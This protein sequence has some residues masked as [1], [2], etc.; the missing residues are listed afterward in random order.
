MS[1]KSNLMQ[2]YLNFWSKTAY[3]IDKYIFSLDEIEHGMLRCKFL[4]IYFLFD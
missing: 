2:T 1:E 4:N 3:K